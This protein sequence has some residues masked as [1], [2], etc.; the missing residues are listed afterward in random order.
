M[1]PVLAPRHARRPA[2]NHL[3]SD[4]DRLAMDRGP[5]DQHRQ[6]SRLRCYS[7]N[8]LGHYCSRCPKRSLFA[9]QQPGA[10]LPGA[11][12]KQDGARRGGTV[13]RVYCP[14]IVVDTGATQT[15]VH[16]RLVCIDDVLDGEVDIKCAHDNTVSY[17]LAGVKIE[18][19]GRANCRCLVDS[20]SIRLVGMGRTRIDY[21]SGG[22]PS[23]RHRDTRR[24][25]LHNDPISGTPN[26]NSRDV[27]RGQ[28]RTHWQRVTH[29][30]ADTGTG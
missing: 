2:V 21:L 17:P 10:S 3:P 20:T 24:G 30:R 13:N 19:G 25:S 12:S 7:C 29:R 11:H 6:T 23:Q 26:R 28:L 5:H 8:E 1:A 9:S 14:D 18:M 27:N 4:Q 16:K 15:L 22:H